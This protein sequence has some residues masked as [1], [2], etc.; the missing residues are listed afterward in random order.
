MTILLFVDHLL[1][2]NY[3]TS[4]STDLIVFSLYLRL[5]KNIS[6]HLQVVFIDSFSVHSRHF[7]VPSHG[8]EVS[9]GSSYSPLL[10]TLPQPE[11]L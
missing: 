3:S 2:D 9:S 6:G 5:C 7:H 11:H 8:R 4:P 10:T 1:G